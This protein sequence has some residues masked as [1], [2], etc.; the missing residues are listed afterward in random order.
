MLFARDSRVVLV[1]APVEGFLGVLARELLG[2][3]VH[4]VFDRNSLS[5]SASLGRF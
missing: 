1:S 5:G 2:R 4:E 3:T